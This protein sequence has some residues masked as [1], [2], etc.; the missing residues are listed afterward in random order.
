MTKFVVCVL[1]AMSVFTF[2]SF[3]SA[4]ESSDSYPLILA[5]IESARQ[6]RDLGEPG[7]GDML[8]R[9]AAALR[10]IDR[11]DEAVLILTEVI[12]TPEHEYDMLFAL[13]QRAQY[14]IAMNQ[15]GLALEDLQ[16]LSLAYEN[17]PAMKN[18]YGTSY[19]SGQQQLVGLLISLDRLDAA[20]DE[21]SALLAPELAVALPESTI[22]S[23]LMNKI[24]ILKRMGDRAGALATYD[25][26]FDRY[27]DFGRDSEL[28]IGILRQR[29]QLREEIN[30]GP[31]APAS[32]AF[33]D[34]LT[35]IWDDQSLHPHPE[36]TRIGLDLIDAM[37][38]RHDAPE[39]HAWAIEVL[40]F[41]DDQ[42]ATWSAAASDVER[43]RLTSDITHW[44]RT[45]LS[46]LQSAHLHG[47][48]D[49]TI[50]ALQE[51][52]LIA[53]SEPSRERLVR[54]LLRMMASP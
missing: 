1:A 31:N 9:A 15:T 26:L 54:E 34:D 29:A 42:T 7:H 12:T 41:I 48:K 53:Q 10:R 38:S 37:S 17:Q 47:R 52:I 5:E 6:L 4:Q 36:I 23:A 40:D 19:G 16:E 43:A 30:V 2:A 25:E 11:T 8:R 33:I 32:D 28:I 35:D 13:R 22:Q 45:A 18:R 21:N 51:L 27:P 20:L 49:L 46:S 14:R 39:R 24:R 3:V 44:R 50:F